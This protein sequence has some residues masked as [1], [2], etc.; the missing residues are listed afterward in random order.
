MQSFRFAKTYHLDSFE[1]SLN[2]DRLMFGVN[3]EDLLDQFLVAGKDASFD[4]VINTCNSYDIKKKPGEL[5]SDESVANL[6]IEGNL[7]GKMWQ[8]SYWN[9]DIV[10]EQ[11]MHCNN[12]TRYLRHSLSISKIISISISDFN[13]SMF[14]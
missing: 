5:F 13:K 11:M 3:D 8:F 6:L 4:Y 2:R 1:D 10:I 14:N 12:N 9:M 7:C